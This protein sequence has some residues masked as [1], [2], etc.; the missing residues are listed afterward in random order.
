MSKLS[1]HKRH[2]WA[3]AVLV[4]L[5]AISGRVYGIYAK[6]AATA[7]KVSGK[8]AVV[9][10]TAAA[11]RGSI[12]A[13]IQASGTVQGI[14]EANIAAKAAGRIQSVP[15]ADGAFVTVGQLLVALDASE[16]QA[17][18]GQA[19]AAR[20]QAVANRENAR[21]YSDRLTEL[22]KE[23]AVAKQQ[24]DNA[25]TQ[26]SVYDAQVAQSSATINLYQAQLS[27][28]TL[29]APFAGQIANKRIVIGDMAAAN[30]ILMTLVDTSKVKV[31]ITL[32]ETDIGKIKVGQTATFKV[33]AFPQDV[34]TA[35]VSEISPAADLKSRTFKV[36]LLSENPGFKLRSGLF[37]RVVIDYAQKGDALKV[38][39]DAVLLRDKQSY[40]FVIANDVAKLSPVTTGL[41]SGK[42]VEILS[43]LE[44][45]AVV[46]VWGH[47]NMN[48]GDKVSIQKR[49]DK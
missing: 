19:M 30:Q 33:D 46:S 17:Q 29:T 16:V 38:P 32:G 9:I 2:W 23:D 44:A 28:M 25:R 34:F 6:N 26:H 42:D 43:G 47:E 5:I 18:L 36:W 10:E 37:A 7:A 4:L 35:K 24:L 20:A 13:A 31:E 21:S 11:A 14:Q 48:D 39:K 40:V 15:V 41:E 12:A 1:L 22:Y 45:G 27:N 49:G 3:I 8:T